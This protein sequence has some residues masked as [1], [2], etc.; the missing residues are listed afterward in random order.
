M[1]SRN[2]LS[3][4]LLLA[5]P[6]LP[7][8]VA[9]ETIR[10]PADESSIQ[11]AINAASAN[12]TILISASADRYEVN[13]TIKSRST[14]TI[15]GDETARVVLSAKKS[16]EPIV[17]IEDS[18]DI[19][20]MNITFVDATTGIQISDS[21]ATSITAN[22]FNL[23]TSG[24]AITESGSATSL[25]IE[26]NT[27]YENKLA[28]VRVSNSYVQHNIF[29]SNT[30]AI[31]N[32]NTETDRFTLNGF[33]NNNDDNG[34]VGK[35]SVAFDDDPKFVDAAQ[36]NFHLQSGSEA[37]IPQ[38]VGV[39]DVVLGAY[40]GSNAD[41]V[42]YPVQGLAANAS[43]TD[44]SKFSVVYTW[45]PIL[46]HR[47]TS[48]LTYSLSYYFEKFEAIYGGTLADEGASPVSPIPAATSSLTVT[49]PNVTEPDPPTELAVAP[50]NQSFRISW[51]SVPQAT[52]YSVHYGVS[53]TAENRVTNISGTQ[54]DITGLQNGVTYKV[55]VRA[56]SQAILHAV[57][58]ATVV[59]DASG[60]T[61]TTR[62]HS[63]DVAQPLGNIFVSI[64]STEIS[65][66]PEQTLAYPALPDEGCFIATAAF[67]YYSAPQVQN[68][69]DFRDRF[70]VTN[71]PGR[72]FVR[73]YYHTS[74]PIAD[75]IREHA[76]ARS[77][78]RV[79]LYPVVLFAS[80]ATQT[81]ELALALILGVPFAALVTIRNVRRR[82]LPA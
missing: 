16:S 58:D 19:H 9:A 1:I 43:P 67:G 82:R 60:N 79:S 81:P 61:E 29:A 49:L 28:V 41:R 65:V 27:F 31:S 38:G 46:D 26:N 32:S 3:F 73:W 24:T 77:A 71:T 23:G 48:G 68:L 53:S 5:L 25:R 39:P 22:V 72:A 6:Y 62:A 12:D 21:D 55:T 66:T 37:I 34:D 59:V 20:I 64:D 35:D 2:G 30:A 70:L 52:T 57:V 69:R 51:N 56:Q 7:N 78:V 10:V 15:K 74:P 11:D 80:L 8:A 63:D 18:D 13:L 14:L 36:H 75:F 44:V 42:P 54:A 45:S 76:A 33:H 47:L 17:S 4:G 50:G 40:G